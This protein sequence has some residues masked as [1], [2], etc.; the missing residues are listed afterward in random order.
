MDCDKRD[1]G[2]ADKDGTKPNSDNANKIEKP[3]MRANITARISG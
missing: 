3:E 1:L 2:N